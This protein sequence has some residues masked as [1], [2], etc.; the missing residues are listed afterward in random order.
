[1][2][3]Q[4]FPGASWQGHCLNIGLA[5]GVI[6]PS[7]RTMSSQALNV[8][9]ALVFSGG[10][11]LAARRD[12]QR[13]F[14]LMWEFPGGKLEDGEAAEDAL[15]RELEEELSLKVDIIR[16]L[17]VLEFKQEGHHIALIPL[18]C[19]PAQKQAPV[20]LDHV[21]IRWILPGESDRLTWAPADIPLV[22]QLNQFKEELGNG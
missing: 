2:G 21:E 8:V 10:R 5:A 19:P 3:I 20:P 4:S 1:M 13:S 16:A 9:C 17:P 6:S 22:E 7:I 12:H 15:H 18:L 14:P 11:V